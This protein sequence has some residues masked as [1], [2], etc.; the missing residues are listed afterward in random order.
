M[1]LLVVGFGVVV[2][3]F[4]MVVAWRAMR[5]HEKIAGQL[6]RFND[7]SEQEAVNRHQKQ[8]AGKHRLYRKFQAENPEVDALDAKERH[9]RFND[10]LDEQGE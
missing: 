5:A 6:K 8:L 4:W 9:A 3:I 2:T 10:W 1:D 7:S